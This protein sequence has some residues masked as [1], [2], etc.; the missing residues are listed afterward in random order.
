MADSDI[1]G[2]VTESGNAVEGATVWLWRADLTGSDAVVASTT[3]DSNGAYIF[4]EHPD[5]TGQTEVWHVAAQYD[6]T[7]NFQF[8]SEWGVTAA[9]PSSVDST[10]SVSMDNAPAEVQ[11]GDTAPID[12]ILDNTGVDEDVQTI[13]LDVDGGVGQVDSQ[14]AAVRGG[15]DDV[16]TLHW[17]TP[18][19]QDETTYTATVASDDDSATATFDLVRNFLYDFETGDLSR[20]DT[21]SALSIRWRDAYTGE[22]SGYVNTSTSSTVATEVP[23]WLNGG[24][25]LAEFEFFFEEWSSSTG[26][27]VR[28]LNSNGNVEFGIATDNPEWDVDAAN[29]SGQVHGGGGYNN[30]IRFRVTFDWAKGTFSVDFEDMDGTAAHT[31]SGFELYHGVDIEKFQIDEY[32]G[33]TWQSGNDIQMNFDDFSGRVAD[34]EWTVQSMTQGTA[35]PGDTMEIT[36]TV[37]NTGGVDMPVAEELALSFDNGVG[38]VDSTTVQLATGETATKTLSWA[39]PSDQSHG[40]YTATVSTP[41]DSRSLDAYVGDVPST[42][43]G[44]VST[45]TVDN[46]DYRVHALEQTGSATFTADDEFLANVLVVGAGGGGGGGAGGSAGGGGGG[47]GGVVREKAFRVGG[48]HSV[49]VGA[50]GTGGRSGVDENGTSGGDSSLGTITAYGGGYGSYRGASAGDG[51]SGGGAGAHNDGGGGSGTEGQGSDG[52]D[53]SYS[54]DGGDNPASG[55]GGYSEVGQGAFDDTGAGGDGGDGY[56][57]S[58]IFGTSYGESGWFGGGGGGGDGNTG[59]DGVGGTG[60]GGDAAPT[61]ESGTA[62]TGGGGGGIKSATDDNAGDGGSGIVLLRLGPL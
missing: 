53:G 51:G 46:E 12:W 29:Y 56:D 21:S 22:Y 17:N 37:K 42:S 41:H 23:D 45:I 7:E 10:F 34:L 30:W 11:V 25:R 32:N 35:D 5:G 55:G 58:H 33:G 24:A 28:F 50:G 40:Y 20:W 52:G 61:P 14:L 4:T 39:V 62:N 59:G 57:A 31:E 1:Q 48:D 8:E 60:G 44:S 2:T 27:G 26:G 18:S 19:N 3:T 43:G 54:G 36:T 16:G 47:A 13:T 6:G 49:T 38:Q 15:G 9:L